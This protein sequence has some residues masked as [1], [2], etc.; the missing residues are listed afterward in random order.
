M[1]GVVLILE[2][3]LKTSKVLKKSD[4]WEALRRD[5]EFKGNMVSLP[6]APDTRSLFIH[7]ENGGAGRPRP[8]QGPR[9]SG[10]SWRR[11]R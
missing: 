2:K 6:Y 10:R 8:Q 11:R 4:I 5:F 9:P 7:A 1:D 3:Y